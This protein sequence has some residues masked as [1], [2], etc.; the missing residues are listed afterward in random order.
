M[1]NIIRSITINFKLTYFLMGINVVAYLLTV[2]LTTVLMG[3]NG[4]ALLFLGAE[5]PPLVLNGE[6]W[7]LVTASFLHGGII[8]LLFNMYALYIVGNYIEHFYGRK[9]LLTTYILTAIGASAFSVI[10]SLWGVWSSAGLQKDLALSVG[11]SGAVF[12]M[13]GVLLGNKLRNNIYEPPLN[14]DTR[15]LLAIV[16]YNLLIGFGLNLTGGAFAIDNWAHCGG[17]ITGI[18]LG[19]LFNTVNNFYQ[20]KWHKILETALFVLALLIMIASFI[21]QI[22]Y[23]I[24]HII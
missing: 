11:A 14:I 21:A 7:R 10:G 9:K 12:G 5:Y 22:L 24:F 3:N 20:P 23:I 8:H 17:L 16:F 13:I 19:L 6:V 1:K 2:V 15:Q 4:Y 18:V